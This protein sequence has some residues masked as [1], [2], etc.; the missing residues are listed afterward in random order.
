MVG[1]DSHA[2]FSRDALGGDPGM[3]DGCEL[4]S[5]PVSTYGLVLL[6]CR[7]HARHYFSDTQKSVNTKDFTTVSLPLKSLPAAGTLNDFRELFEENRHSLRGCFQI[8]SKRMVPL[9][10]PL[11]NFTSSNAQKS[12]FL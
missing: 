4:Y 10:V 6:N 9:K 12:Q 1:S 3:I 11:G 2:F 5:K 8:H 7:D